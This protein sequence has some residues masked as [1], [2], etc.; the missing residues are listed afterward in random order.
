MGA[1][2]LSNAGHENSGSHKKRRC[3]S[4]RPALS[5]PQLSGA[6]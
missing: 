2:S 5:V 6:G 1:V 4:V 3:R